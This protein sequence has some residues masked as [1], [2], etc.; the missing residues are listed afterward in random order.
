MFFRYFYKENKYFWHH[1]ALAAL[2]SVG[3]LWYGITDQKTFLYLLALAIVFEFIQYFLKGWLKHSPPPEMKIEYGTSAYEYW[4]KKIFWLD[5][6]GDIFAAVL[7]VL[8][9]VIPYNWIFV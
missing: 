6:Y 1:L 4:Q 5:S 2:G 8:I 9:I 3:L 7:G